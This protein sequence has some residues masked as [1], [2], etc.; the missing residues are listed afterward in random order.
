MNTNGVRAVDNPPVTTEAELFHGYEPPLPKPC[1]C[2]LWLDP[3]HPWDPASVMETILL[4]NQSAGH[5][6]WRLAAGVP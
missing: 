6:A 5:Q 2:G 3:E 1:V 4:H